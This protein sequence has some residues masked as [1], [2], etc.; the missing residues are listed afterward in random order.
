MA[1]PKIATVS[2]A[3]T[4]EYTLGQRLLVG[5][6]LFDIWD[7]AGFSGMYDGEERRFMP[8]LLVG[9][10]VAA[11]K[12]RPLSMTDAFIVMEAKHGRTAAKYIA[13]AESQDWLR[14]V[15]DPSGDARKTLLMPSE[16]LQEKFSEEMG[17]L[18]DDVRQLVAA[19]AQE[20]SG[21]P[22]TGAAA[23]NVRRQRTEENRHVARVTADTAF[24]PRNW[25]VEHFSSK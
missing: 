21:L 3:M 17:R 13:L 23:F 1:R 9:I 16:K 20:K 19:L 24:P 2:R 15:R 5:R 8:R 18:A 14:K 12:Q 7:S 6:W 10:C 4:G 22:E 11:L 25:S